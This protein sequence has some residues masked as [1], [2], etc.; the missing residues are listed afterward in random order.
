MFGLTFRV[1]PQYKMIKYAV[2]KI[3]T[4]IDKYIYFT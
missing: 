1:I 2:L 3:Y 4:F